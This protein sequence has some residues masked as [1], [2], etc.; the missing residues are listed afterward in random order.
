MQKMAIQVTHALLPPGSPFYT[1][2]PGSS[3]A[4][5]RGSRLRRLRQVGFML[6]P[7]SGFRFQD[8]FRAHGRAQVRVHVQSWV[9][10]PGAG[11]GSGGVLV[12]VS[13]M[14]TGAGA[15]AGA[16]ASAGVSRNAGA[17]AEVGVD[18]DA[19]FLVPDKSWRR[20][21]SGSSPALVFPFNG[22]QLPR[23]ST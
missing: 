8:F 16:G 2:G 1:V 19:G 22:T 18:T 4:P 5:Q 20:F 17:G 11:T 15:G 10:A 14:C 23:L 21:W 13:G 6:M 3:H 12:L 7:R 9:L